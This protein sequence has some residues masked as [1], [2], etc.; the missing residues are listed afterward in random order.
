MNLPVLKLKQD[1]QTRW[2]CAFDMLQRIVQVKDAVIATVALLRSDLNFNER[3]WEI[4][5]GVLPLLSPF[6]EIT[7]EI[8]SERNVTLSKVIMFR[9]LIRN[10]L[11]KLTSNNIKIVA[12]QSVLKNGMEERFR[13]IENNV[14]YVECTILDLSVRFKT[15]GFKNQ[16]A[17][18]IAVQGLRNKIGKMQLSQIPT[19]SVTIDSSAQACSSNSNVIKKQCM[20]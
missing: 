5:E 3:D 12:V 18:E 8:S 13:D 1:V 19:T 10:F 14:L 20:G 17:C 16:R 11:Q 7:L 9:N 2:N 6:Y 4:I 15:R